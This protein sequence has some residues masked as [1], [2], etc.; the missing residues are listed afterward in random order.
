MTFRPAIYALA[1]S[2][3]LSA[4][5]A[6]A[7]T[8]NAVRRDSAG[9]TLVTY[10]LDAAPRRFAVQQQ[11]DDIGNAPGAEL[12]R[13]IGALRMP[14]GRILVAD[15]GRRQILGFAPNGSLER[16]LA[17]N[18]A[19]PGE[20]NELRSM[21]RRGRDSIVA[22]DGRQMRFAVYSDSAF[23]RQLLLQKSEHLFQIETSLL[24]LL[25]DGRAIVTSG[26]SLALGDPGPARVERQE[27]PLV[28]YERDG[29]AGRLLGRYPGFEIEVYQ[30]KTGPLTG[31]FS[32][33]V[34]LFGPTTTFALSGDDI[35]VVDNSVFGFD[36]LNADGRLIRRVRRAHQPARVTRAHMG[37]YA[38]DRA[39]AIADPARRA[40]MRSTF[41]EESHAPA[42]PALQE[43]LIVGADHRI[44]LGSYKRP[45]DKEQT[46]WA[47][48][49]DGTLFGQ[50]TV[51]SAFTL[52]DAGT[53]YILG[54]WRNPD[55]VE[56]IRQ[57]R[58]TG[59]G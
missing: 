43:R 48:G 55:G 47:F 17:R 56:T 18:G 30:L 25:G 27:F 46:W 24:G 42:F 49:V 40:T 57:Y 3:G 50:M 19:G 10:A 14:N 58:L 1:L 28:Q 6:P 41:L 29:R 21:H 45:G 35:L 15:G 8:A 51:P 20:F 7:Q 11:G 13:V 52:T 36:V 53:D 31:G 16:L 44:W 59:S 33:H 5:A 54:V 34:R 39:G 32:K 9:I 2:A 38:D 23:A 12:T 4:T 22:H 37:A 26:A